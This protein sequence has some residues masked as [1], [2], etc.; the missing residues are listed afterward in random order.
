[1]EKLKTENRKC[2]FKKTVCTFHGFFQRSMVVEP[3]LVL[4][5]H[6]GGVMAYPVAIIE[7]EEG[8]VLEVGAMKIQFKED[9][10]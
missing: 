9:E 8:E 10:E 5:G 2:I 1:M 7:T 4:G 6:D 3:S